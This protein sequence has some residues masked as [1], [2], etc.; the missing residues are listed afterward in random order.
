MERSLLYVSRKTDLA[1]LDDEMDVIGMVVLAEARNAT[2]G[3]TGALV[4]TPTGFA[5]HLEGEQAAIHQLMDRIGCDR[6]HKDVTVLDYRYLTRRRFSRWAMAYAG[7]TS[8]MVGLVEGILQDHWAFGN[9][10]SERL[11]QVMEGFS[12]RMEGPLAHA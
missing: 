8:Y 4:A 7:Q 6:R 10:Q 1:T 2:L 9:Q 5:Q 3:V 11:I 12:A